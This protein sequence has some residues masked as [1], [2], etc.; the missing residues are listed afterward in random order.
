MICWLGYFVQTASRLSVMTNEFKEL[1]KRFGW[2][3]CRLGLHDW[4]V[5]DVKFEFG[6]AGNV[7]RLE[8]QRCGRLQT[9]QASK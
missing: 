9:R 8:C 5:V 1:L 3:R 6:P 2:L 4:H 7:E